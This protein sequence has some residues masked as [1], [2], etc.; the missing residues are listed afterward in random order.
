V[1]TVSAAF[2]TVS[3]DFESNYLPSHQVDDIYEL[4][5]ELTKSILSD[6]KKSEIKIL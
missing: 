4:F 3:M 6:A 1:R 5:N 2:A